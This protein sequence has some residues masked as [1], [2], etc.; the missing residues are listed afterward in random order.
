MSDL[1]QHRKSDEKSSRVTLS[2]C[3]TLLPLNT[4]C[5]LVGNK[6]EKITGC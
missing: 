4:K 1:T 2:H 6:A 3:E 5:L